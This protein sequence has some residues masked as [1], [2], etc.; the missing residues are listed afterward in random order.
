MQ[1][2]ACQQHKFIEVQQQQAWQQDKVIEVQQQAW[3]QHKVIEVQQQACQQHKVIEVQQFP[4]CRSTYNT[5][6]FKKPQQFHQS[7]KPGNKTKL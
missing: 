4:K 6:L 5:K 7:N 3:Q 2:Q 1:Q